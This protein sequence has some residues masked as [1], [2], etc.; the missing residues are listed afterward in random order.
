MKQKTMIAAMLG[1]GLAVGGLP[2]FAAE[3]AEAQQQ[4]AQGEAEAAAQQPAQ[5]PAQTVTDGGVEVMQQVQDMPP[6]QAKKTAK[7]ARQALTNALKERKWKTGW[8]PKKKRFIVV[9]AAEIDTPDPASNSKF[10]ELRDAA[11]KRA[12]LQAKAKI[13]EFCN[14]KMSA[15]DMVHTPGTDVNKE[16][17]AEAAAI[18]AALVAEKNALAGILDRYN[19]AEAA[20]LRGTTFADRLD[21]LMAAAIKKIDETYNKDEKD[22]KLKARLEEAKKKLEAQKAK[23]AQLQK[24]A[25]ALKGS[26]KRSQS[27]MIATMAS[28]PLYGASAIMQTESYDGKR[29]QVAIAMVWSIALERSARAI[30]TGEPFKLKPKENGKTLEEWLEKQNLATF[31]GPRQFIDKDG[32]RWFL[33]ACARE[34]SDDLDEVVREKN[35]DIAESFAK[36]VTAFS[37]MGDVESYKAARQEVR[38]YKNGEAPSETQVAES[39]EKK[40]TQTITPTTL[41]GLQEVAG[42]EVEHPISG[43]TIYVSVYAIDPT[44]AKAALAIE[45]INYATKIQHERHKTVERGRDAANRAAVQAAQNRP[46]DFQKGANSQTKALTKELQKRQ[47]A[48]E[49]KGTQM[50]IEPTKKAPAQSSKGVYSGDVDVSDDF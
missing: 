46:E 33:G 26:L 17:G 16:L 34:Y 31:V 40:L 7:N 38:T 3:E 45:R 21:D 50:K 10:I 47:P 1:L 39:M 13:I 29:Y 44:S 8:D 2:L 49:K 19:K 11:I 41:R 18:E 28:M 14:T 42:E 22:Q 30:V 4:P 25:N 24:R 35:K 6:V 36:S 27:S 43:K 9:E 32:R 15:M 12:I 48:P 37:V 5:E 23:I 20:E